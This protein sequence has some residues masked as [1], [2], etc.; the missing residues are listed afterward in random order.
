MSNIK[1]IVLNFLHYTEGDSLMFTQVS[2]WVFFGVLL[3]GYSFAYNRPVIRSAYLLIFS[4]FF[5]FKSSGLFFSLLMFST[6]VDYSIGLAIAKS[7]SKVNRKLLV[8]LSVLVNLSVLSYFKY[9]Y[10]FFDLLNSLLGT[11]LIVVNHLALWGNAFLNT[12][13]DT[14][15]IVLPVGISF[16]TFQTISYTVDVYRGIVAP[17]RNIIDFAFYV[18]FFPQLVAGPIVRAAEFIPQ[19]Y[20]QYEL[21]KNEFGH[22]LFLV[23]AGLVKKMI[24]SD[25]LSV[26]FV[27]RV[28]DNPVS[29]TGFENLMAT[30]GYAMQI[31]CD[32]SGYTD[33][34]IGLALF[35][36]FKL[37]IN[38][39]SPYKANSLTDF[40]HRWHISLSSWLRDY[41]YIPLGGNRKG[42]L[43]TYINLLITMLLG[44]LWHG[45]HLKFVVWGGIHGLGLAIEKLLSN[46]KLL[47]IDSERVLPRLVRGIITFNVVCLS[48]IFFRANDFNAATDMLNH[49]FTNF[50]I[51]TAPDIVI[52]FSDVF[53]VLAL[54]FIV[55]LL[56]YNAKEYLR[57]RFI[58][59]PLILKLFAVLL[60]VIV[61][62]Q[63]QTMELKPFIYFRF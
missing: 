58:S 36:G 57:G 15:T 24:I 26:N 48:W 34:A 27:D 61:L 33:I 3:I 21:S 2:F 54:G 43:R 12:K 37:P 55:H 5:Y 18:S 22:A 31:Y 25:Y 46:F 45:A 32:F 17:V 11:N 47:S 28:F 63:F 10:F 30:Y 16:Y 39:N 62:I 20:R 49:I 9:A 4:L 1:E 23:L 41:L 8:A 40:W 51:K 42:R 53:L 59:M 56:P 35:L 52:A 29:H 38:F 6:L 60:I 19:I 13:F 7:G 50:G 14:A 44:G